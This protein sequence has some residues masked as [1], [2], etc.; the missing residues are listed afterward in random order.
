MAQEGIHPIFESGG[1]GGN[2]N[3][4]P[5]ASS[6]STGKGIMEMIDWQDR[7]RREDT[8]DQ[9]IQARELRSEESEKRQEERLNLQAERDQHRSML[10]DARAQRMQGRQDLY[11]KRMDDLDK[12]SGII[13]QVDSTHKDAT[14]QLM[15]VRNTP[16]FHRLLANRDTR[17]ALNE[18]WKSKTGE[19]KDIRD[20]IQS[21]ASKYG[22]DVDF[23]NLP[24][25]KSGVYDFKTIYGEVIPSMAK[26][27]QVMQAI[28]KVKVQQEAFRMGAIPSEITPE[29]EVKGY[30]IQKGQKP[31]LIPLSSLSQEEQFA[32]LTPLKSQIDSNLPIEKQKRLLMDLAKKSGY[33]F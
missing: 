19:V 9:L 32:A 5:Y 7:K 8:Q 33:Q 22:I 20:G 11:D 21:E 15:D 28:Q 30:K 29:G 12:L 14:K 27:R 24:T 23:E 25:D 13:D 18:I 26:Q 17:Q 3:L 6:Y 4:S 31:K 16:E 1:R 2:Y 10:E